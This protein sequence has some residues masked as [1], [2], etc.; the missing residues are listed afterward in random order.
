VRAGRTLLYSLIVH[1]ADAHLIVVEKPAGL[2]THLTHPGPGPSLVE[3]VRREWTADPDAIAPVHRL[4]AET[5]GL[6]VLGRTPGALRDLGRQFAAG[7][8]RKRY[9]AV[10]TGEVG[11]RAGVIDLPIGADPGGPLR[12]RQR[13]GGPAARE[14]RTRFR[15][16]ARRDGYSL[17][18]LAPETGRP[19]QIRVH[20]AAIG[21]PVAGDRLYGLPDLGPGRHALHAAALALYHPADG[22]PLRFRSRLPADLRAFWHALGAR[23]ALAARLA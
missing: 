17:L 4:D 18:A 14:A 19:H 7:A 8:V 22:R 5:S 11:P 15:V 12:G 20:L 10:V 9:L 1:H 21:H 23:E 13:V 16:L 2:L 3:L 6:V